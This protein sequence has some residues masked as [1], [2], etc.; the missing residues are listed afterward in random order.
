MAVIVVSI[1]F[2]R[3]KVTS[4]EYRRVIRGPPQPSRS[5]VLH[6]QYPLKKWNG[7]NQRLHAARPR[8]IPV[9]MPPKF[10]SPVGPPVPGRFSVPLR[11][12]HIWKNSQVLKIPTE[13][14][15]LSSAPINLPEYDY[16]IQT[17]N[18]PLSNTIQQTDEKG[19]IHTIPAPNLS[20]IDKPDNIEELKSAQNLVQGSVLIRNQILQQQHLQQQLQQ[21]QLQQQLQQQQQAQQQQFQQEQLKQ[22]TQYQ[23]S[24]RQQQVHNNDVD[25]QQLQQYEVTES[26]SN[27]KIPILFAPD[28]TP[29]SSQTI[30]TSAFNNQRHPSASSP[31]AEFLIGSNDHV[32]NSPDEVYNLLNSYPQQQ[33]VDTYPLT[34]SQQP[35]LQQHMQ[36]QKGKTF[37]ILASTVQSP[38]QDHVN[39]ENKVSNSQL[40]YFNYD[41][42]DQGKLDRVNSRV[43]TDYNVTPYVEDNT[44]NALAQAQFIQ[45]F[46]DTRDDNIANNR[47]E[48]EANIKERTFF[49]TLPS[50]KAA[51][52]LASLQEA[53]ELH[54]KAQMN[55]KISKKMPIT[56]YVPDNYD[57]R[58]EDNDGDQQEPDNKNDYN[59]VSVEESIEED[60]IE[61]GGSFGKRLRNKN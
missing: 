38:Q 45:Y 26:P 37:S 41:E 22:A 61:T 1:W 25:I 35:Q 24:L 7:N 18:I 44:K 12:Q 53:G 10:K 15:F 43:G 49:S 36:Q 5:Q 16:H 39:F 40:Q 58:N 17:N 57:D 33:L 52:T 48:H 54:N 20:L 32:L 21:Q 34:I 30:K 28:P 31:H 4:A 55:V 29:T 27:I 56:I 60:N 23:Q 42:Q 50:K 13:K 59:D 3:V 9:H 11:A 8:P 2:L 19:P 6:H 14:P 46:F 47:V 51:E